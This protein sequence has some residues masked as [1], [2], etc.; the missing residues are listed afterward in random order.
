MKTAVLNGNDVHLPHEE[1]RTGADYSPEYA[2]AMAYSDIRRAGFGGIVRSHSNGADH[3]TER[4]LIACANQE[5]SVHCGWAFKEPKLRQP[6]KL[7]SNEF[8]TESISIPSV[9]REAHNSYDYGPDPLDV[10][11]DEEEI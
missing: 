1:F 5:Y 7:I 3:G 4:D 10:L 11:C 9:E 8:R 6:L 2:D